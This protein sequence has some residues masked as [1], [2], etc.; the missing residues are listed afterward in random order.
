MTQII[1]LKIRNFRG[2]KNLDIT[3]LYQ[4]K[5]VCFIGRG[6]SG[7]TTILDAIASALLQGS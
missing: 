6:D 1:S 7:K 5:I 4:K 2:I 3:D